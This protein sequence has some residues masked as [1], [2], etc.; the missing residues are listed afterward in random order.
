M[1]ILVL[2]KQVPQTEAATDIDPA[3]TNIAR[4]PVTVYKM[5]RF[6]EYALEEALLI[7]DRHPE[8]RV[9]VMS[10]GPD[11]AK[12]VIR[13]AYGLGVDEG[14]H[15]MTDDAV[16]H[17]PSAVAA[18][19]AG[20]AGKGAYDLILAGV[21]SEDLMQ[22]QTGQMV[23]EMLGIPCVASV[24]ELLLDGDGRRLQLK[25]ELEGGVRQRIE[26]ELPCVLTIQAGI[27]TP[28]YPSLS[29]VLR[30][31]DKAMETVKTEPGPSRQH[32]VQ[33]RL[34]EKQRAGLMVEGGRDEKVRELARILRQKNI[35]N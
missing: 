1:N 3:G 2:I 33:V 11:R 17:D 29:K 21:M 25:R 9:D 18:Q 19:I 22:S 10:L 16:C 15:L 30:A 27:N 23:A 24:V 5:N 12:E 28:R 4:S 32:C 7:K 20:Q 31:A 8:T 26:A 35:L 13:R 34:P 6:D 14:F